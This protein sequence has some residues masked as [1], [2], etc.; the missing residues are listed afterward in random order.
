MAVLTRCLAKSKGEHGQSKTPRDL[1]RALKDGQKFHRQ[2]G[3]GKMLDVWLRQSLLRLQKGHSLG[4]SAKT[5]AKI[6]TP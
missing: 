4:I 3:A 6:G 5:K 2:D 1:L